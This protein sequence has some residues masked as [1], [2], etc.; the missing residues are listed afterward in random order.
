MR[1]QTKNLYGGR[2]FRCANPSCR[3]IKSL[4]IWRTFHG[5]REDRKDELWFCKK[6]CWEAYYAEHPVVVSK[7]ES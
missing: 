2:T 4:I 6:K 1:C 7:K 3:L 5:G